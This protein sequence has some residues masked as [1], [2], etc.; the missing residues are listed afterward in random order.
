MLEVS[1][2][3]EGHELRAEQQAALE[4]LPAKILEA[5]LGEQRPISIELVLRGEGFDLRL[6][7][8]P[9][10][11]SSRPGAPS[12]PAFASPRFS[13]REGGGAEAVAGVGGGGGELQALKYEAARSRRWLEAL[14]ALAKGQFNE[15][16]DAPSLR[17]VRLWCG[18]WNM[19]NA[20]PDKAQL[21]S[22][23]GVGGGGGGGGGGGVTHE[24]YAASRPLGLPASPDSPLTIT[25]RAGTLSGCRSPRSARPRRMADQA[26]RARSPRCAAYLDPP[27]S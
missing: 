6:A 7:T 26:S 20:P 15:A 11:A 10:A 2:V 14:Q 5:E 17:E 1:E 4:A 27:P 9:T 13:R 23:L 12:P 19:G 22:W 21:R 16:D 18:T 3:V 24:L 25:R 8:D